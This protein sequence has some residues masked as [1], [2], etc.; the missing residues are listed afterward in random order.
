M[1][2]LNNS[3][4]PLVGLSVVCSLA[5]L[6]AV[7]SR[8]PDRGT[9]VIA[10]AASRSAA[11]VRHPSL[12]T[13]RVV[14][15][16]PGCHWFQTNGQLKRTMRVNGPVKLANLDEATLRIA[17]PTGTKMDRVGGALRLAPGSYRITMVGQ[18]PDDNTLSLVV[19]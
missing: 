19:S 15:H 12:Q 6:I 3:L 11:V 7:A 10:P 5:A 13:V 1:E 8:W 9:T 2:K 4:L 17:G 14:M 18:K 16:D